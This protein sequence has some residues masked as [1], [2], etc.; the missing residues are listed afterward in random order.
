M[1][2]CVASK[3]RPKNIASPTLA[4]T[5]NVATMSRPQRTK[6]NRVSYV[7]EPNDNSFSD[8]ESIYAERSDNDE[9]GEA[10]DPSNPEEYDPDADINISPGPESDGDNN[11][12]MDNSDADSMDLDEPEVSAAVSG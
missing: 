10:Q 8:D 9:E 3:P 4:G 5:R 11:A 6:T 2:R 1:S 12:M 7:E